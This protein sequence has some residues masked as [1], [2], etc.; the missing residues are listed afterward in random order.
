MT[1]QRPVSIHKRGRRWSP[2]GE[3]PST[4]GATVDD[5]V[6]VRNG[7]DT[8]MSTSEE[9]TPRSRAVVRVLGGFS[10]TVGDDAVNLGGPRQRAVLARILVAGSEAVTAEQVLHDVWDERS[11]EATVGAVQAYVSRLRR[12]LGPAALPRRA[13]GYVLD[14]AVV[15]VDADQFV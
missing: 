10:A 1:A 5:G 4:S 13:D 14:R 3:L 11:A 12:L 2:C 7:R 6:M 8:A 15:K 9:R